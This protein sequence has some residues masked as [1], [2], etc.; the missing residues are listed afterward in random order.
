MEKH[1]RYLEDFI[2]ALRANGRYAFALT[3]V[4]RQ[5]NVSNEAIKKALQ[6]L[7]SKGEIVPVRKGFYVVVTPEYK[8]RRIPPPTLF[9]HELMQFLQRNYYIG[10]LNAAAYY[11]ASHQQPQS[12]SVVTTQPFL[13]KISSH[14]TNIQFFI[15]KGWAKEDVVQKKAATG[16]INVSS[17]EL[18]ALDLLFYFD[19]V[20]GFN[21]IATILE[22]L[23]ESM[24]AEKLAEAA[25]RFPQMAAVQRL[26]FLLDEVLQQK[27]LSMPMGR[28]L[29]TVSCFPILLRPQNSKWDNM[30]TGNI[31]KVVP[32]IEV[33]TD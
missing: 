24:N 19:Q 23:A 7:R 8:S 32:N 1:Y 25:K 13:R 4:H 18:T 30:V 17:P 12:F 22:E 20:G 31:W 14:H 28:Y 29:K 2:A 16:Y 21:R 26:G 15:K 3:E 11:G 10:L 9:I 27:A 5:F 33:E 6:R